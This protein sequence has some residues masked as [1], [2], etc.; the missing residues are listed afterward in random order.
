MGNV[1]NVGSLVTQSELAL[2]QYCVEMLAYNL[3]SLCW[4]WTRMKAL[5]TL[6]V[7]MVRITSSRLAVQWFHSV[8]AYIVA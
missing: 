1:G 3:I 2:R 8:V 5:I 4:G 6:M 7:I